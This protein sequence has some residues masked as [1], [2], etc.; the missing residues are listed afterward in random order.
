MIRLELSAAQG[1]APDGTVASLEVL[2]PANLPDRPVYPNRPV[3]AA[4][5][6]IGGL[7][8]GTILMGVRRWLVVAGTGK[9]A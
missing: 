3:I 7:A 9:P 6:L 5:G 4:L 8:L 2:D 1:A